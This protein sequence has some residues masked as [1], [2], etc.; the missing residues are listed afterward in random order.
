MHGHG[1]HVWLTAESVRAGVLP[2][3]YVKPPA[4]RNQVEAQGKPLNT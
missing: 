3:A 4:H 1:V 2:G